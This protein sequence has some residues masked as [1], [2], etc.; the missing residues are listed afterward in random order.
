VQAKHS[1][2]LDLVRLPQQRLLDSALPAHLASCVR[3]LSLA[4]GAPGTCPLRVPKSSAGGPPFVGGFP[5]SALGAA[6]VC[7]TS[8]ASAHLAARPSAPEDPPDFALP[9]LPGPLPLAPA[10]GGRAVAGRALQ[11]IAAHRSSDPACEPV[12]ATAIG[13]T[14]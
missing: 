3:L 14:E 7:S 8:S 5:A 13:A 6:R 9:A 2:F 1:V 4:D 11:V 10:G 12:V